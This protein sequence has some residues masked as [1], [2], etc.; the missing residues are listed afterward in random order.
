MTGKIYDGNQLWANLHY[1]D[2]G[3]FLEADEVRIIIKRMYVLLGLLR[4]SHFFVIKYIFMKL[5]LLCFYLMSVRKY[6][7]YEALL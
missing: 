2:F 6:I 7:G 5:F 4:Q 1:C 3:Y